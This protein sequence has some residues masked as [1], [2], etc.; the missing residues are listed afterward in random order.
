MGAFF[1]R[2]MG[3]CGVEGVSGKCGSPSSSPRYR[4][5]EG[6]DCIAASA[7]L[8]KRTASFMVGVV[9]VLKVEW[10]MGCSSGIEVEGLGVEVEERELRTQS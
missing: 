6:E 10:G 3:R 5:F 1:A 7:E 4:F 9:L 2:L 8:E